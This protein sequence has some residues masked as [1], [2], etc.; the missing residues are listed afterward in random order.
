MAASLS[1][2]A[3]GTDGDGA[4]DTAGAVG[5]TATV[6]EADTDIAAAS[7]DAESTVG[8]RA[9]APASGA[10]YPAV[11]HA[12]LAEDM[13]LQLREVVAGAGASTVVAE[14]ASTAAAVATV[15][16]DTGKNS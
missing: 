8:V 11:E 7:L 6:S 15:A 3:P 13:P 10:E 9:T 2:S 12:A 14:A 5:D 1:V 4:G 16:A